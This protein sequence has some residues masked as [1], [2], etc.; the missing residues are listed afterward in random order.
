MQPHVLVTAV[1]HPFVRRGEV[2][3]AALADE[4]FIIREPGSGTRGALDEYLHAHQMTP[5]VVMQMSSDEA[6]KLAVMCGRAWRCCRC[7]SWASSL[8]TS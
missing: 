6:I 1:D 7:T 3:A 8:S 5:R 4:G 2:P